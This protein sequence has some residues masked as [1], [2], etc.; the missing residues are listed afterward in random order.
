M[1]LPLVTLLCFAA[2]SGCGSSTSPSEADSA[3]G[4]E[5]GFVKQWGQAERTALAKCS[6]MEGDSG[7]KCFALISRRNQCNLPG[8]E[9]V[10]GSRLSSQAISGGG[11]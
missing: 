5:D 2:I 9:Q 8:G 7:A 1:S 3:A 4:A 10:V 11:P 6:G